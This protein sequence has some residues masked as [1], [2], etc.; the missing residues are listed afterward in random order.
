MLSDHSA[1]FI[2]LT[3]RNCSPPAEYEALAK[4]IAGLLNMEWVDGELRYPASSRDIGT[5]DKDIEWL[6]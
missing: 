2:T 6:P 5:S 4:E 3:L 1:V